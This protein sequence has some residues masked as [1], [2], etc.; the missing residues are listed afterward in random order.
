MHILSDEFKSYY[1]QAIAVT[2]KNAVDP[3]PI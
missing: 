3:L 1:N 2:Y